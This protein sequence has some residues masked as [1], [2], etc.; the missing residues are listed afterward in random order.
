MPASLA[1]TGSHRLTPPVKAPLLKARAERPIHS[2]ALARPCHRCAAGIRRT[3]WCEAVPAAG[4]EDL[5]RGHRQRAAG[6]AL[7]RPDRQASSGLAV[8]HELGRLAVVV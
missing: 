8:L 6:L 3:R 2:Y 7:R 1:A 5:E 4:R